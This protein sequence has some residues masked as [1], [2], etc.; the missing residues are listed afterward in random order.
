M[1]LLPREPRPLLPLRAKL[2]SPWSESPKPTSS[3]CWNPSS[4]RTARDVLEPCSIAGGGRGF[5]E[6]AAPGGEG[7]GKR[8]ARVTPDLNVDWLEC[9]ARSP[10]ASPPSPAAPPPPRQAALP[11]PAREGTAQA[12]TASPVRTRKGGRRTRSS[13]CSSRTGLPSGHRAQ[14]RSR[15]GHAPP[16]AGTKLPAGHRP[17][18][19]VGETRPRPAPAAWRGNVLDGR[20]AARALGSSRRPRSLARM[21]APP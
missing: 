13:T 9:G 14:G 4:I 3:V 17:P 15:R 6:R 10:P 8:E 20:A 18:S 11:A 1:S 12:V 7:G 5:S 19:P 16:P 21:S 2:T